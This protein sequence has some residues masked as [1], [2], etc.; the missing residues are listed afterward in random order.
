MKTQDVQCPTCDATKGQ[1]CNPLPRMPLVRD[2]NG[3]H[4]HFYR[5]IEAARVAKEKTK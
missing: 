3:A 5:I 4:A 2:V 1:P